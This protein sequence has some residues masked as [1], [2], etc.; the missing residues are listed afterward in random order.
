[1]NQSKDSSLSAG[2]PFSTGN[3]VSTKGNNNND[4]DT[5]NNNDDKTIETPLKKSD[6]DINSDGGDSTEKKK[7]KKKLTLL[8]RLFAQDM[9]DHHSDDGSQYSDNSPNHHDSKVKPKS[10]DDK[11]LL[12]TI[13]DPPLPVMG[14]PVNYDI[15]RE[16]NITTRVKFRKMMTIL[17]KDAIAAEIEAK[18]IPV[19]DYK[20]RVQ[21]TQPIM[22]KMA[23]R[24]SKKD[25]IKFVEKSEYTIERALGFRKMFIELM[26]NNYSDITVRKVEPTKLTET[27][28]IVV[29]RPKDK[30]TIKKSQFYVN[31]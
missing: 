7:P 19:G 22:N 6:N 8:Q 5:I 4:D 18:D 10:D 16:R 2:N 29:H 31:N 14:K 27:R 28:T 26:N 30:P 24:K 23:E 15:L 9:D 25:D 3:S 21:I 1:M 20:E 11:K 12:G 17:R 13:I